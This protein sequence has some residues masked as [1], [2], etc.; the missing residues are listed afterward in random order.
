MLPYPYSSTDLSSLNAET[1]KKQGEENKAKDLPLP[2]KLP[3]ERHCSQKGSRKVD[4]LH[5]GSRPWPFSPTG[6]WTTSIFE[7]KIDVLSGGEI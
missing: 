3:M 5:H 7:R 1:D 4:Y 6:F 2:L